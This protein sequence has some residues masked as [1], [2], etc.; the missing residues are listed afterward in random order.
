[1][2]KFSEK[3]EMGDK[4]G[5]GHYAEVFLCRNKATGAKFA[6]KIIDKSRT[7]TKQ[8]GEFLG[9]VA[10]LKELNHEHCLKLEAFFDEGQHVYVVL[11][12]ITGGELFARICA[13]RHF[14]ERRA[15]SMMHDILSGVAYLHKRG[16]VHRD[17]KPE[18]LLMTSKDE[19]A[20]IKIVDFG[21]AEKCGHDNKLTKCC[22]TP[23]Y[24]A[25]EVLNAGLYKT[26]PPY[27]I[28][29]DV[30]SLG[31]IMYILL[32]GYPPFRAKTQNDQF[33]RVVAGKYDFPEHK[34]WGTIS[35]EAKDLIK[36]MIVLDPSKRLTAEQ[37][38]AH[39]W[40]KTNVDTNLTST[41]ESLKDFSAERTWKRGI[42][43]VEALNRILYLRRCTAMGVKPNS[44]IERML[45][46]AQ[47]AVTTVD[48]SSNYVGPRGLM[49]LLDVI[50]KNDRIEVLILG[51]NGANNQVVERLCT[52][53]RTHPSITTINLDHNPISHLAGR[54][55]L[56][57]IQVNPR[58]I[59]LSLEGTVL[60][61]VML[62][63]IALQLHRNQT[64]TAQRQ[65]AA[66]AA[67][68][69]EGAK[70]TTG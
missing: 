64:K 21:F 67:A 66:A 11:E 13:E 38:L 35:A 10:I 9:E 30:W 27:G 45:T 48:L 52:I 25:P 18:N 46:E 5:A 69:E 2:S 12:L 1:M 33:K 3:F 68:K 4:L 39:P 40:M 54:M 58:I 15:A 51:N 19:N 17:L 23:L 60:Q 61:P 29:S 16:I 7:T 31:V 28:A 47:N 53:L 56:Y 49:A 57:A 43:G 14:S 55:I 37:C 41:V 70:T 26:G 63:R 36:Q 20:S 24:I 62:S 59:K 44:G 22:G 8:Q 6:V 42:Y 65:A 50:E 34:V 32:C